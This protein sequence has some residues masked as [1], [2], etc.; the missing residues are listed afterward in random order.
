MVNH[1]NRSK[2]AK[3]EEYA[4]QQAG[5]LLLELHKMLRDGPSHPDYDKCRNK[6]RRAASRAARALD[7]SPDE[8]AEAVD[9]DSISN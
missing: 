7:G 6:A 8:A 4:I 2:A 5:F 3:P 1:P 9:A